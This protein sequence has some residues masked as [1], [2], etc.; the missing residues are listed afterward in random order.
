MSVQLN[1]T[2][3][4][5][6]DKEKSATF[7]TE[8]LGRPRP[9]RFG[10][11]LVVELE[12]GVSLDY[13]DSEGEIA[14]QHYAFLI[15]EQDFDAIFARIRERGLHYWA[16]PGRT[17]PGEINRHDGGRGMYFKDPDGHLLEVITRPYGS[18]A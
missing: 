12:N 14:P 15:G 8:M 3:V 17:R 18:G 13:H 5:C 6:S 10:P 16:D 2:I 1:H 11:F 7:L 9:S 4:W